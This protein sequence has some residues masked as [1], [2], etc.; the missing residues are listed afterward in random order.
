MVAV[1]GV[2]IGRRLPE[3]LSAFCF[4]A[5]ATAVAEVAVEAVGGEPFRDSNA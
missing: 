2:N 1:K 4:A 3:D 5:T